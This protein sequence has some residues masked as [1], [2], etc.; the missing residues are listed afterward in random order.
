MVTVRRPEYPAASLSECIESAKRL[1]SAERHTS[2]TPGVLAKALG[3]PGLT[4]PAKTRLSALK[5]YRL[6]DDRG[7][8]IRL[9]RLAVDILRTPPDS[10]AYNAALVRAAMSPRAFREIWRTHSD[11][12]DEALKSHLLEDRGFTRE[13]ARRFIK[14]FRDTIEAANLQETGP[15]KARALGGTG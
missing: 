14:S 9:S 12:S 8:D 15:D 11:A 3:Y 7:G 10:E 2:V 6:I 4:R 13:G 5:Q 1:W